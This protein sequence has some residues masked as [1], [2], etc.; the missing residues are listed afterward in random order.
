MSLFLRAWL[1]WGKQRFGDLGLSV[2]RVSKARIIKG[3]CESAG[4][5]P[6]RRRV[7]LVP[8]VHGTYRVNGYLYIKMEYF[9][10]ETL[11]VAWFG[12][13]LSSAEKKAIVEELTGYIR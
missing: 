1:W 11:E 3:P 4:R 8:K 5:S 7:L 2:V 12:Y 10:G 13:L 9:E 6:K